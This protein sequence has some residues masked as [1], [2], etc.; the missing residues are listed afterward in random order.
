M[1]T[2]EG[3]LRHRE[4]VVNGVR[5]HYVEAGEGPL[6]VLLHGFPEFWYAWRHQIPALAGAGFRVIAADLRGYNLSAKPQDIASYRMHQLVDDVLGLIRHAGVERATVAGHDW[7]GVI[8]WRLGM[9]HPEALERLI[10]LNAP[11]P[12]TYV[13][14]VRRP[15]QLLRSWYAFFFQLPWLPEVALRAG[16]FAALRRVLRHNPVRRHAYTAEDLRRYADAWARPGALTAMLNYYRASM[17]RSP[18][19]VRREARRIDTPTLLIW[20]EQ[21]SGLSPRLTHGLERWVAELRIER[22]PDAS[23]WVMADAP[24]RVNRLMLDFLNS[25]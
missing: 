20:G 23:H 4:A 19:R 14:E 24:E 21:D 3:G 2:P 9:D 12:A 7:G 10:V 8:G 18:G 1:A 13:R 15:A 11:H 16:N 22:I 5:L 6:V 17:R 25:A